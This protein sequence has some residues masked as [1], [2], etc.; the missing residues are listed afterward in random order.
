MKG[1]KSFCHQT[2]ISIQNVNDVKKKKKKKNRKKIGERK[3]V[4]SDL[5]N[6]RQKK[7]VSTCTSWGLS[8]RQVNE[9]SSFVRLYHQIM[10]ALGLVGNGVDN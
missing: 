6:E 10:F 1:E 2:L 7:L 3:I 4:A 8:R 9:H 5:E